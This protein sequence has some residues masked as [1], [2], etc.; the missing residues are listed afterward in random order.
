LLRLADWLAETGRRQESIRVLRDVLMVTPLNT[1]VHEKLGAQLLAEGQAEAAV[2]EF[3]INLTM[4]PHD[5]A[6]AHYRL[7][8][9]YRQLDDTAR[10]R[11][12]L[13]YALEIA[14]NYREA[15]QMLLEILR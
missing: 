10:V 5:R 7:A 6:A 9:A 15:Q 2:E 8:T 1:E 11:E 3:E 13:L 14:P 4:N 12:H